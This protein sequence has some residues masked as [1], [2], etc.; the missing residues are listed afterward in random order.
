MVAQKTWPGSDAYM[1]DF[2]VA[3]S[4][5]WNDFMSQ[6]SPTPPAEPAMAAAYAAGF[7]AT[8]GS[9]ALSMRA[10]YQNAALQLAQR[11]F[12]VGLSRDPPQ[13][14]DPQISTILAGFPQRS[15][16]Q[17]QNLLDVYQ[18]AQAS[19]NA[20]KIAIALEKQNQ[21]APNSS[22]VNNLVAGGIF[23]AGVAAAGFI[24]KLVFS[25]RPDEGS[26]QAAA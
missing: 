4:K 11:G 7:K 25:K 1:N 19:G 15:N 22:L 24:L 2:N 13:G 9:P 8:A 21:A 18:S 10:E 14:E 3:F 20:S 12:Q 5:A 16:V 23:V 6:K 17:E 26:I